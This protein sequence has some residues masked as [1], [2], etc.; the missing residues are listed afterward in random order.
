MVRLRCSYL[1]ET[2]TPQ[3][4]EYEFN[5]TEVLITLVTQSHMVFTRVDDRSILSN[6]LL[7]SVTFPLLSYFD[8]V[9]EFVYSTYWACA[10][11]SEQHKRIMSKITTQ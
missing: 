4:V 5:D 6:V 11:S 8:P 2:L 3:R 7:V 1:F 10:M 9:L